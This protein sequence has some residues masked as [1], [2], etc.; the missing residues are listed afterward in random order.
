MK[1]EKSRLNPNSVND[2]KTT[3]KPSS[4]VSQERNE[5]MK[6]SGGRMVNPREIPTTLGYAGTRIK[7]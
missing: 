7:R 1:L 3:S 5:K 4:I 2:R 6:P